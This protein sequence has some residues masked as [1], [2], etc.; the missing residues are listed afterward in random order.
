MYDLHAHIDANTADQLATTLRAIAH[1]IEND[2]PLD[3]DGLIVD[4]H[5]AGG[6]NA[7]S[8][9]VRVTHDTESIDA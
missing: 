2:H 4:T 9:S 3:G 8:W 5:T 1:H 7:P 6:G